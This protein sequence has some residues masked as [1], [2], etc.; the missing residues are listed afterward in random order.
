MDLIERRRP[1]RAA[2]SVAVLIAIAVGVPSLLVRFATER[3]GGPW[4]W[5]GMVPFWEWDVVGGVTER[6]TDEAVVDVVVRLAL[7]AAWVAV[8][9]IVATVVFETVHLVRHDGLPLPTVR[10]LGWS[11]QL[12]HFIAAGLIVLGPVGGAARAARPTGPIVSSTPSVLVLD[13]EVSSVPASAH[14]SATPASTRDAAP[15]EYVVRPGDSVWAIAERFATGRPGETVALAER[16]LELNLGR[17]MADGQRFTNA[18]YIEPG[19]TLLLPAEDANRRLVATPS[20]AA[21]Y[22]VRPGDTLASIA[23]SQ[24][25]DAGRWPEIY[26]ANAGA[27]MVDGRTFDDPDLIVAGW[28]LIMPTAS[29][30]PAAPGAAPAPADSVAA[31]APTVSDTAMV[32]DTDVMVSD[33]GPPISSPITTPTPLP[34]TTTTTT[35]S[36]TAVPVAVDG[37][38]VGAETDSGRTSPIGLGH[39]AM[40]AGGVLALV[41]ARRRQRLRTALPRARV[42]EPAPRAIQLERSLRSVGPSERLERADVAIR[43]AASVLVD[44]DR[45]VIAAIVHD[46]GSLELVLDGHAG[47]PAPWRVLDDRW[48]LAAGVPTEAL[49]PA[50]RLVG[51]PCVAL[52][53]L[54]VTPGGSDVFVDLEALGVLSVDAEPDVA[55]SVVTALAGTLATS[56]FAE[57]AQLVGVGVDPGAFL[58]HRHHHDCT[59]VDEA[60]ELATALVGTTAFAGRSTFEM[61]SRVTGGEA[62]EPAVLLVGSGHGSDVAP[63]SVLSSATGIAAVVAGRVG[64]GATLVPGDRG[65]RL[66]P[67]GIEMTPVG[68]APAEVAS[69]TELVEL[70]DRPLVEEPIAAMFPGAGAGN[71]PDDERFVPSPWSLMVRLLGP[72]D[73]VDGTGAAVAFDRSKTRELVA[74]LALHR[75]RSTRSGARTALWELDVRDATFANVVS[76]ARRAMARQVPP[77]D[78]DEWVARTLTDALPLHVGIVT[79]AD[80]VAE[81]LAAARVQP[82]E[83]AVSTLEPAVELIRGLPFEGTGYLWPD[84]EGITSNLVLLATSAAA[85]LAAHHLSMGDVDGVFRATGLGLRVL[86][87]H[88]ELIALRMRAHARAGDHAGVR[89]EWESYERVITADPW[90]DGEPAPKLVELRRALLAPG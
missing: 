68:L 25:G 38:D 3:F 63:L 79:D 1:V 83:L 33:T 52:V 14:D 56:V 39:A 84:A 15:V 42:P 87:G 76:E 57:V 43:A 60:V 40:L 67:L 8:V 53:Q 75:E 16:V 72:V 71:S 54:G 48:H 2:L 34:T 61:R 66:E 23:A 80:L 81:R 78:G 88:E 10:G 49:A 41:A 64:V 29:S 73:V 6:L 26:A 62:W 30:T 5:S 35:T 32:S 21:G 58:G 82:P 19:W 44:H 51:C 55:D 22:V 12:A 69:L 45:R 27:A 50:A 20:D 47:A 86:P 74:W 89:Q 90:S 13:D 31:A 65:W 11:Q 28:T 46:D 59:S 7:A 17:V 85:E 36:T 77:P 9:V 24:L 70:V 18:A 4:P 37:S